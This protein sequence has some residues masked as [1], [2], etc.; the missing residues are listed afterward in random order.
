MR[1]IMLA[2]VA[3]TVVVAAAVAP[4]ALASARNGR[5]DVVEGGGA[6]SAVSSCAS[7]A[8]SVSE[9]HYGVASGNVGQVIL[10]KN[11]GTVTCDLQGYPSVGFPIYNGGQIVPAS[12]LSGFIGGDTAGTTPPLISLA[13][14][15]SASS[16]IE[17][18]DSP[19][20]GQP[21][22]APDLGSQVGIPG[23]TATTTLAADGDGAATAQIYGYLQ[24]HPIV[25]GTDGN[26][27]A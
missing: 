10:F 19:L 18:V 21:V 2:A 3:A 23:G 22:F 9:G 8:I 5:A 25:P 15:Q 1:K 13:P 12:T 6:T 20:A 7:S 17:W 27:P 24:V 4:T 11:T 16:L 14:G 26:D